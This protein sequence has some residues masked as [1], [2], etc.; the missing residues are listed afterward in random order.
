MDS[1]R[2]RCEAE[3]G[4]DMRFV[5][6]VERRRLG[7]TVVVVSWFFFAVVV[8]KAL[9]SSSTLGASV[10]FSLPPLLDTDNSR[11]IFT[12]CSLKILVRM[13]AIYG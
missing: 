8:G 7:T 9:E 4:K 1:N 5:S 6:R 13:I 2:F 11:F 12:L 3:W 10:G